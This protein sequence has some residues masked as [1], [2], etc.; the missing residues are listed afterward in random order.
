MLES[1]YQYLHQN[2]DLSKEDFKLLEPYFEI[3][4]FGKGIYLVDIGEKENYVNF[5]AK[6]LIRK[7]FYR[8]LEEVTTHL[9]KEAEV[10][11]SAVSF[12]SGYP[13][14][15]ILEA[16][17]PST[18]ISISRE[19]LETVYRKGPRFERLGRL[20]ITDW[21]LQKERWD[22]D[23]I[24]LN[25]RDRFVSFVRDNPGLIKRVPQKHL[26]SYLNITPE[27]YSRFKHLIP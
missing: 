1:L 15:Y 21:L 18:T 12:L 14:D 10:A 26:A 27:T 4:H 2:A 17:E 23:W 8:K 24:V 6:G 16:L 20:V 19:N 22:I 7:F 13:S 5:I 3:R 25:P 11:C 9:A